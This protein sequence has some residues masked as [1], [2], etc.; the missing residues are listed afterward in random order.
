MHELFESII[1]IAEPVT[2]KEINVKM[3][4]SDGNFHVNDIILDDGYGFNALSYYFPRGC[5]LLMRAVIVGLDTVSEILIQY[6][7][8]ANAKDTEY[9]FPYF[10]KL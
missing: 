10:T 2:T 1:D 3:L 6:G 8:D 9:E 5:T 7:A 4:L